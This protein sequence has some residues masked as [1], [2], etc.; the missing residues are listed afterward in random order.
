MTGTDL[1]LAS[2]LRAGETGALREVYARY[3]ARVFRFLVRL[4]N[5][6]VAAEDLFQ[7]TWL[8]VAR[9]AS[10]V[11]PTDDLAPLL[12][13]IAR[14]KF[15]NWRRWA[16]MDLSRIEI[17]RRRPEPEAADA[18]DAREELAAIDAEL[19]ELPL[20]AREILLLVGVEGLEPAQAAE[21]LGI[22][23]EAARQRLARARAQL[24]ERL[25]K[26][27]RLRPAARR[28]KVEGEGR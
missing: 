18:S 28:T 26:R 22:Q 1:E 3:E 27:G 5:D 14:N 20:A 23:P 8:S 15:L 6:R 4:T 21:V 11:E 13:T 19:G 24:A 12:F 7:E 9:T 16:V 10:R 2:R 25:A 17:L